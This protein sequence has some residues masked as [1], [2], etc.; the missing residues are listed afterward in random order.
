MVEPGGQEGACIQVAAQNENQVGA[1]DRVIDRKKSAQSPEQRVA[2]CDQQADPEQ[3]ADPSQGQAPAKA[4]P[5][6]EM[7]SNC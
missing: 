2:E 4:L 7:R 3:K 5:I 1:A 6:K